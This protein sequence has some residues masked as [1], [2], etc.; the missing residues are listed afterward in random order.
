MYP[1]AERE[2]AQYVAQIPA[3]CVI[4]LNGL[5]AAEGINHFMLAVTGLHQTADTS[6]V[7]H[8]PRERRRIHIVH[9]RDPRCRWCS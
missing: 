2:A 5:A 6:S 9:R 1:Q 7:T 8:L 3:P 4:A